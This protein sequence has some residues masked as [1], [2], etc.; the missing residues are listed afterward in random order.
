M[1]QLPSYCIVIFPLDRKVSVDFVAP[2]KTQNEEDQEVKPD[3]TDSN[4]EDT[5]KDEEINE[6]EMEEDGENKE[7]QE[8]T[9]TSDHSLMDEDISTT[10]T[11]NPSDVKEGRTLFVRYND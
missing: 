10:N 11:T 8:D 1:R 6:E 4:K 5:I 2:K 3:E 7:E 9:I